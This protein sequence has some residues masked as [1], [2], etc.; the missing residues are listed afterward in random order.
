M[1][2]GFLNND[3]IERFE[4]MLDNREN[5]Y[6]DTEDF[7][8][9]I[10]YYLDVGDLPYAKK[11]LDYALDMHPTSSEIQI[12]KLEY[13]LSIEKLRAAAGLIQDLKEVGA[14]DVDYLICV[15]RFW[16]L[17]DNPKKA[18]QFYEK[19]LEQG[20]DREYI[21]NCMGNEY[22]N[23]NEISQA[24]YCFKK[25]LELDLDD[26][27]AF[28]SCV[29]CFEDLHLNKECI[30]FL[31]QYIDLRPYSDIAWAQL[32]QQ[33]V[34]MKDYEEA[35][36]AF[37]YATII[38][39][40]SIMAYT[41]KAACLEKLEDYEKAIEVYEETLELDDSAAYTYLKVGSCYV[42]LGKPF[43]AL[44][45]FHQSIH[46]DPQ[47]DQ[48]WVA[49][50][51]LYESIGNYDEAL[52]YLNRALDLDNLNI[53]YWKRR[54][55]LHIQLVRFEE[56][57]LDY[58]RL[59]ELEPNNFY[60]W[61]G[62][63]E[64]LITIG[65]YHKAIEAVYRSLKHFN[66]AELYYQLSNCFYLLGEEENGEAAFKKASEMNESL[67]VEMFKKYPILENRFQ[68]GGRKRAKRK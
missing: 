66:R 10:A 6:F 60:N 36:R 15:A 59:V 61:L 25:A 37:D 54:A 52:Y 50:S 9:I 53:D 11:A 26:D 45:S 17:K 64:T 7:Y 1:E 56:S 62:L 58:Y 51:D 31:L 40:K 28:F 30:E 63:T 8:E 68:I 46:E 20:D 38:N 39:P 47:L 22:L 24:L 42:K 5:F 32:G 18:I 16:S 23:L 65:D 12:K 14:N 67:Q 29:Q 44:K 2:D 13:L 34:I 3:L 57:T 19:A 43:K 35:H 33:Y 27:F 48:A 21:Y 55:Y 4:Q 41:Q 49:T